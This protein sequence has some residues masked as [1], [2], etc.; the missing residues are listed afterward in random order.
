MAAAQPRN[1]DLTA[2]IAGG[3]GMGPFF[4]LLDPISQAFAKI[5]GPQCPTLTDSNSY[6]KLLDIDA[7]MD[8]T[9]LLTRASTSSAIVSPLNPWFDN[10]GAWVGSH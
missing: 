6:I 10:L 8:A 7:S 2:G 5:S 1:G 9:L 3:G 4:A